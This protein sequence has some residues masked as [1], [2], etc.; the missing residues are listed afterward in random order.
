MYRIQKYLTGD[1]HPFQLIFEMEEEEPFTSHT[2]IHANREFSQD[3]KVRDT[4]EGFMVEELPQE[5]GEATP[6]PV[7]VCGKIRK[8]WCVGPEDFAAGRG[9]KQN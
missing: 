1:K 4:G 3:D 2:F 5:I 7:Y 6:K 9:I 8:V